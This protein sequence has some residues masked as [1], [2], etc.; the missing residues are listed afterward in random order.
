MTIDAVLAEAADVARAALDDVADAGTVGEQLRAVDD[1]ER[2]LTHLF[3][4]TQPG[5]RGWTWAVSLSRGPEDEHVTV[6]DVVLLPGEGALVAPDWT[7][8]RERI[9]PGDLSP[10]DVLPPEEDDARLVPGWSAGDHLE[11][12]DRVYAREV[13]LGREWVLSLEGRDLAAQRWQE[14]DQGPDAPIAKQAPGTCHSCG[15]LV[16]LAGPLADRF[17]VCANGM[18]NDDGRVVAFSHGCG[19]HTGA[20]LSRSASPQKLPPPVHDTVMIDDV[21]DL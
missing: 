17:G 7:P 13:G 4:C 11:T 8:Y 12:L 14:G 20:R 19:A 9:Q 18:A 3:V 10:G 1:G 6:N 21:A 15:F 5:Y 2:L 16:S